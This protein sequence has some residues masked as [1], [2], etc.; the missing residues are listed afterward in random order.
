[1]PDLEVSDGVEFTPEVIAAALRSIYRKEFDINTE[2]ESHLYVATAEIFRR[3]IG[4]GVSEAV[5]QGVSLPDG[6]FRKALAE[7][8]DVFSAFRTHEM[9]NDIAAQLTDKDGKLKSFS[10]FARDVQPYVSHKNRAWL[11]TEYNTAV[12]RAQMASEWRQFEDEKDIL[13]NLRWERTTSI[14]PGADH[15][16]FWG[17]VRPIDDPFW[18]A[19][20]PGD[21]WNCKCG[22]EATD[23]P[24]TDVPGSTPKDDPSPGLGNNPGKDGVLFD[25][26]HPYFAKSCTTCPFTK[27]RLFA[28]FADLVD[29]RDCMKCR[30]VEKSARS[31]ERHYYMEQMQPLLERRVVKT[32]DGKEMTVEFSK[33]GNKHL[34]S[35]TFTRSRVLRR[36]DLPEVDKLLQKSEFVR[37]GELSK[38][39]KDISRFYYFEVKLHGDTV[40]LN[41]AEREFMTKQGR[42]VYERFLYSVTDSIK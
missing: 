6:E 35:D 12:K 27:N 3:A 19:H 36:E 30:K 34:F 28:L 26:K 31:A 4:E 16:I 40:Y 18:S 5:G 2:L 7:S 29:R 17:V 41:V 14:N 33:Q 24:E 15:R 8:A 23:E 25:K 20:R 9:Q 21:R 42:I 39:R 32:V 1:M 11:R 13:P 37:V 10:R 22:L 38:A